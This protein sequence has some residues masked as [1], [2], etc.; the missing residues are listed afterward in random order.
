MERS[1]DRT[2]GDFT[3]DFHFTIDSLGGLE[4]DTL[5]GRFSLLCIEVRI[6]MQR[7]NLF[8]KEYF[9]HY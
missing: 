2:L 6:P 9:G 8:E 7:R 5:L 1:A 4:T 3:I